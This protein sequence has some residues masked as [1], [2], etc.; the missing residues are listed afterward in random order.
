MLAGQNPREMAEGRG[1]EPLMRCYTH[2]GL[3]RRSHSPGDAASNRQKFSVSAA[4]TPGEIGEHRDDG[5][6][7]SRHST[8]HT[9]REDLPVLTGIRGI[10]A[11]TVVLAHYAIVPAPLAGLAVGVFFALSG[12]VLAHVYRDGL[13]VG[14]FLRARAARTLPV[15]VVTTAL[16]ALSVPGLGWE[17]AGAALI[18]LAI[19]NPP[20]WSLIVE[21]YAYGLFAIG[22]GA[23]KLAP[24]A[25]LALALLAVAAGV[26][27]ELALPDSGLFVAFGG[28]YR[29]PLG[30][31][32]FLAGIGLYRLGLRPRASWLTDN[33]VSLWLGDISYPLYLGHLLPG[34]WLFADTSPPLWQVAGCIVAALA[35]AAA[36]HHAV[37]QPGRRMLRQMTLRGIAAAWCRVMGG[38]GSLHLVGF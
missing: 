12:F 33:R 38:E 7:S 5:C 18:G 29:V 31:G 6:G 21:W 9:R 19:V 8:R 34:Y 26:G 27:L 15:H 4:V 25:I 2:N 23:R 32:G 35:L 16:I 28:W 17:R 36:L 1:F 14:P 11:A 13:R 24:A 10:A 20:A 30:V 3:A 22:G 37:E